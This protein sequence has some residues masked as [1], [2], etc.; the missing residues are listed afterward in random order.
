MC[1]LLI[2][3]SN[4]LHILHIPHQ[5]GTN[6]LLLQVPFRNSWRRS[7]IALDWTNQNLGLKKAWTVTGSVWANQQRLGSGVLPD[8]ASPARGLWLE[9]EQSSSQA[10]GLA[11]GG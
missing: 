1:Y 6:D 3:D 8:L 7:P 5:R 9:W 11:L 2:L 4:S 10:M